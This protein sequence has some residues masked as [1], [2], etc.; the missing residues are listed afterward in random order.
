M[1]NTTDDVIAFTHKAIR[2]LA[3]DCRSA[4]FYPEYDHAERGL[5]LTTNYWQQLTAHW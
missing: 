5:A 3:A 4:K 1:L 2:D